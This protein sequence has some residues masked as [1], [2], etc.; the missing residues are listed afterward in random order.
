MDIIVNGFGNAHHADFQPPFPDRV[1]NQA[2][3]HQGAV[4]PHHEKG[5]NAHT[6]QGVNNNRDVLRSAGKSLNTSPPFL[7]ILPTKDGESS[8]TSWPYS[9]I[10]PLNPY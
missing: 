8:M 9:G 3:G 1:R 6:V 7:M 10:K 5:A 4:A 2:G